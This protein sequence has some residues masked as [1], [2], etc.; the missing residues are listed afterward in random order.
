MSEGPHNRVGVGAI[1]VYDLPHARITL[2]QFLEMEG[3]DASLEIEVWPKQGLSAYAV[4]NPKT[5]RQ[6]ANKILEICDAM[7]TQQLWPEPTNVVPMKKK[8]LKH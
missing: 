1:E 7:D 6:V 8:G 4:I 3:Q 2:T 5:A